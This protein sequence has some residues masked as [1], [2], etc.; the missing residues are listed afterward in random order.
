MNARIARGKYRPGAADL[1]TVSEVNERYTLEMTRAFGHPPARVWRLLTDPAE[2]RQWAPFD[3]TFDLGETGTTT[4]SLAGGAKAIDLPSHIRRAEPP[5]QLEYTWGSDVLVWDLEPMMSG[6][7]L[8]LLHTMRDPRALAKAAAG[9]Q[10][11]LDVAERHL[12]GQ[13]IGRI[14]GPEAARF[15]WERLRAEQASRFSA[16]GLSRGDVPAPDALSRFR[17]PTSGFERHDRP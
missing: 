16:A 3:T 17:S 13:P 14:A 11:C 8:T 1:A 4:L 5:R 9:W 12:D 7:V 2:I 10:I 15:D 6:T